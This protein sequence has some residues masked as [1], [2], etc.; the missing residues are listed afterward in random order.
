MKCK[1]SEDFGGTIICSLYWDCACDDNYINPEHSGWCEE[2]GYTEEESINSHCVEVRDT[3]KCPIPM[4]ERETCLSWEDEN[5]NQ[6]IMT[7]CALES[8]DADY[9]PDCSAKAVCDRVKEAP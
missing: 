1:H 8:E 2:C 5:L 9:C 4:E 7:N 3:G 6:H